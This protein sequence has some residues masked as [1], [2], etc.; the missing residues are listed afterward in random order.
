MAMCA[1][2]R[3]TNGQ[4]TGAGTVS[5]SGSGGV[6]T[7]TAAYRRMRK[8]FADSRYADIR[9]AGTAFLDTFW[10]LGTNATGSNVVNTTRD[11]GARLMRAYDA[12]STACANHGVKIPSM[13][14]R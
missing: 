6:D 4:P 3:D 10:Q 13:A 11:L 14:G 5:T 8:Q 2:I 7:N 12:L 1:Q 9:D